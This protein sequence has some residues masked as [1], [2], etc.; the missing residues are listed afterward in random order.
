[1]GAL[2]CAVLMVLATALSAGTAQAGPLTARGIAPRPLVTKPLVIGHRGASGY[3]PEHT[4]AAYRLAVQQGADA[5]DVDVVSSRDHELVVV[6]DLELSSVTD[7]ADHPEFA[8]RRTTKAVDG[9]TSTGWFVDDFTLAELKTLR[10][11][12]RM[13]AVRPQNAAY[14]GQF[15][16]PT[17][18][19]VLT[20]RAQ[21]QASTGRPIAIYPELKNPTYFR[22]VDLDLEAPLAT[23]LKEAGLGTAT[24]PAW[25]QSF[26]PTALSRLRDSFGLRTRMVLLTSNSGRPYDFQVSG[27]SRTYA[28]LL[29]PTGLTWL[30]RWVSAIGP[31][32]S[33]VLPR[34]A[35]GTL[36]TPTTLV[37][38][39]HAAGLQVHVYTLR[40]ENLFLPVDYRV[41][42]DPA[43]NGRAVQ[44]DSTV[45]QA[46][47]DGMFCDQPDLCVAARA[48][49]HPRVVRTWSPPRR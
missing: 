4:L 39:V 24:A 37:A 46:G 44:F 17:L 2:L 21:L 14:D 31:D 23:A 43:A 33:Q 38:R 16:I 47:V 12:E 5:F 25:V 7:V 9:V 10:V 30:S 34:R 1:V 42:P 36:G 15:E 6:H 18:D 40:S 19:E 11:R 35:D 45:L 29:T 3:R 20:L 26:E 49:V 27:D 8:E 13:P 28:D 32:Q 22:S 48:A 41:G